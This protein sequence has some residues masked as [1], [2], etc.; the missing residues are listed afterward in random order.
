[1]WTHRLE[2]AAAT[3]IFAAMAA[4]ALIE[5]AGRALAG[6]GVPGSIVLVQHLTLWVALIGAG[7]AARSNSLLALCTPQFLPSRYREA[8]A[9]DESDRRRDVCTRI[10]L[11]HAASGRCVSRGRSGYNL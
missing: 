1:V 10:V 8:I 4:L 6:T 5:V 7:L 3:A 9:L 11:G 2:D